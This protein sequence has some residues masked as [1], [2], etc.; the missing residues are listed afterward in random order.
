MLDRLMN[1][2]NNKKHS[3]IKMT[4]SEGSMKENE[5]IVFINTNKPMTIKNNQ[6]F[7]VSDT[8]RISRLKGIFEK[9]YLP[10]WSEEVYTVEEV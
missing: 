1:E 7:K 2:Y 9:G 10:N 6:K 8:V 4:P 5:D 3:T